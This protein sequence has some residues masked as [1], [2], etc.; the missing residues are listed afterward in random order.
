[1]IINI[2]I[3]VKFKFIE[4]FSLDAILLIYMNN[5]IIPPIIIKNVIMGNQAVVIILFIKRVVYIVCINRIVPI[6]IGVFIIGSIIDKII[7]SF[8]VKNLISV[9]SLFKI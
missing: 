4:N 8:R 5:T 9:N 7:I 3:K 6:D 1:M 2:K